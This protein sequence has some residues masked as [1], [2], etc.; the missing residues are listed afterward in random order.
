MLRVLVALLLLVNATYLVWSQG[1]LRD[2]GFAPTSQRE[3]QRL[4][5]QIQPEALRIL[6]AQELRRIEAQ[7]TPKANSSECLEAGLFDAK[8]SA[9]L[10]SALVNGLPVNTW[11]LEPS[12]QP[13]RWLAYMGKYASAEL[14]AKKKA[15]LKARGVAYEA[16]RNPALEPGISLGGFD[17]QAKANQALKDLGQKGVRTAKVVLER[18]EQRGDLLRLAAVD[19]SLRPALD[20][21]K[22]ALAGRGWRSC[23]K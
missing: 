22:D 1:W 8:Q 7:A 3:P 14:A 16:L 9:V 6:S 10:R 12:V 13:A 23:A 18:P 21:L 4:K 20:S 15:E 5:Q 17:S 11:T 19:D 2:L